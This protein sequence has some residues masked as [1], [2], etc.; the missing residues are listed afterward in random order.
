MPKE[1]GWITEPPIST[2]GPTE[3]VTCR[4]L[5][6]SLK[7]HIE[8]WGE[9]S[10]VQIKDALTMCDMIKDN[11]HMSK[12]K[13]EKVCFSYIYAGEPLAL[14]LLNPSLGTPYVEDIV[15]HPGTQSGGATMMEYALNYL[16]S[17]NRPE[18]LKLWALNNNAVGP[19]VGMGF[20]SAEDEAKDMLLDPTQ[21]NKWQLLE[22]RWRYTSVRN[23]GN[24]YAVH[25]T[26]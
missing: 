14:M 12:F 18:K 20:K 21:S 17:R 4:S 22:G 16:K 23:T 3:W 1:T 13:G 7:R 11:L 15:C 19:Y 26:L 6:R 9:G 8:D 24:M 2:Y 10:S 5:A 25:P